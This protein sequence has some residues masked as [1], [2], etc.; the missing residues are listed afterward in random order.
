MVGINVPIPVPVAYYSFGGWKAS[1][2]G[3]LHMYGPEGV[4]FYTRA[5]VVT[6]RW[7]DPG[8]SKVDLGLPADALT[9]P[10]DDGRRAARRPDDALS[11][12]ATGGSAAACVRD[13]RRARLPAA[14]HGVAGDALD[15]WS[16]C[17]LAPRGCQGAA[18]NVGRRTSSDVVLAIAPIVVDR[19]SS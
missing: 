9:R 3:D 8:T 15:R 16:R 14:R 10:T 11:H 18:T 1:L 2:F 5:K 19:T 12:D 13:G 17:R 6:A 7:P 4:Q